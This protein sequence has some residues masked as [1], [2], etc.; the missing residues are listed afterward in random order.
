MGMP[1]R[2]EIIGGIMTN[3]ISSLAVEIGS[4]I[5][6]L[7]SGLNQANQEI[8][9]F[10][11]RA[12]Q[13]LADVGRDLSLQVTAPL[14]GVG[15]AAAK[16]AIDFDEAMTNTAAV[17][18]LT[19]DAADELSAQVLD[20]G[21]TARAG[22]QAVAESFYD[23]VGGVTDASTH[24]AI[25]NAAIA[26]SEAGNANLAATTNGLI[27]VM[28]A[29]GLAA[30]DAAQ[31]SDIFTRTVGTG[32]GT[33][34]DFVSALSPVAGLASS[35]GVSFQELGTAAAFMTTQGF[36][37][38]QAGTRLQAAITA[39]IKPN[40]T[41]NEALHRMGVESG[42]AA[43]EQY[44]LAGTLDLLSTALGGS[45]DQMAAALGSTEALGAAILLTDER[46][47]GFS[48]NFI[49]GMDGATAAARQIQLTSVAA[50]ID[51]LKSS[52]TGLGIT[53]GDAI[54]PGIL[55]VVA[56]ITP[57]IN[58]LA[59]ANP[60]VIQIG[61]A[62]A[63]MAAAAGPLVSTM[64]ALA[65]I[66]GVILSPIGL[67]AA[68]VV[69]AAAGF[70]LLY[71]HS[72]AFR[73]A[74]NNIKDAITSVDL[75]GIG[76]W[77]SN[78]QMPD[79]SALLSGGFDLSSIVSSITNAFTGL[80]FSGI[81]TIFEGHFDSILALIG[82]AAGIIF[83]GPV[84][85]AIGGAKLVA[86]AIENDFLGIGTF[87]NTSGIAASIE[88]AI[89]P[90]KDIISSALSSLFGGGGG[91]TL[92]PLAAV[93][94]APGDLGGGG[95]GL[96]IVTQIQDTI[97]KMA[98]V[99]GP[100]IQPVIDGL[101]DL[102]TGISGFIASL[103]GTDANFGATLTT[104]G[105][106]ISILGGA[107]VTL[108]G[109][110]LGGAL[111]G[112]GESLKPI[113]EGIKSFIEGASQISQGDIGGGLMRLAGGLLTFGVGLLSVPLNVATG[114]ATAI[115]DLLGIDVQGGLDAFRGALEMIPTIITGIIN[116]V[117]AAIDDL[118]ATIRGGMRD[119]TTALAQA[120]MD[121]LAGLGAIQGGNLTQDQQNRAAFLGQNIQAAD[122]AKQTE[123][124][125]NAQLAG[126]QPIQ[127]TIPGFEYVV[128]GGAGEEAR[129]ALINQIADPTVFQEAAQA[130]LA[131]GNLQ[132]AKVLVPLA[133]DLGGPET[134]G[135]DLATQMN[136]AMMDAV[137]GV[138]MTPIPLTPQIE[139]DVQPAAQGLLGR[140]NGA[141]QASILNTS[142][143]ANVS[144]NAGA[145]NIGPLAGTVRA[146]VAGLGSNGPAPGQGK[147]I[148]PFATG[149]TVPYTGLIYAHKGEEVL[150]P[151]DAAAYRSGAGGGG[152]GPTNNFYI[153]NNGESPYEMMERVRRAAM[154]AAPG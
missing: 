123:Q 71:D 106:G 153:Q 72:T 67:I 31:V 30:D 29:Y 68:G 93:N 81:Q 113:G 114:I 40:E 43:L 22:P 98:A 8:G 62:L 53:I 137:N 15:V 115:G 107:L 144:V 12:G 28:N 134:L 99:V 154:D 17:M 85:I 23:I 33:M 19:G 61:V 141:V 52:M 37:A 78:I 122:I 27:S 41:M 94:F 48:Q 118:A 32:V 3:T 16:L 139:A 65:T 100:A 145:V 63:A 26:T 150:N 87:L 120:E 9:N 57:F 101:R 95:G 138:A 47:A 4:N 79:F 1:A 147:M 140:L 124:Q 128:S 18:G 105:Q 39:L 54:L 60:Q 121:V 80:D 34:D 152:G 146:L 151:R 21:Q 142:V 136:A 86:S 70:K 104:L 117:K 103:S 126:G 13:N 110:V 96:Q 66:F 77:F 88:A 45:Q 49:T 119:V 14:V 112:L 75:S 109:A 73:N 97:S 129:Q 56:A 127:I 2:F 25:L 5:T 36:S 6:G 84:G 149:G 111:S 38:S 69:A 132:Q 83:G 42:S 10:A 20:I 130:A 148:E 125:L 91:E 90:I 102:G 50:Q 24:M 143:T 59:E 82:T 74:I 46:F 131:A 55:A 135:T 108:T 44:G 7:T 116:R 51:L 11:S 92:D 35:T 76:N 133:I 58:R 89:A 64:G